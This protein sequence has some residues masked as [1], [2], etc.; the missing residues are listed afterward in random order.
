[1]KCGFAKINIDP[2]IGM[3]I[4]GSYN[5]K[6]S[7]G[8]I[9]PLYA[10]AIA[11]SDG[12]R[13]AIVIALDLCYMCTEMHATVRERLVSECGLDDAAI[14]VT[15]SHTHAGPLV[16]Y[17]SWNSKFDTAP[18]KKEL[19]EKIAAIAKEAFSSLYESKLFV[20]IGEAKGVKIG[21]AHV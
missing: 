9:D 20:A 2:P 18:Y 19:V 14:V 8:S 21:R 12:D 15:C 6:Y 7:I 10:R 17:S 4:A 1:M 3:P 13:R 5:A 16:G 11:F